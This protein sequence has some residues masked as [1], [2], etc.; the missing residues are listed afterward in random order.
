MM[1][2]EKK[3]TVIFSVLMTAI[4]VV[5]SCVAYFY[6]ERALKNQIEG[7]AVATM[8]SYSNK[9]NGWLTNKAAILRTKAA[10]IH[11][12]TGNESVTFPMVSGIKEAD[13]DIS[14]F[15]FGT[16][17]DGAI[18]DGSGWTPPAGF[19]ARTR[20]WY[21]DAMTAGNLTFSE[22]YSDAI[23]K[24]IAISISMPIKNN[25]G[26]VN[27]VLSEDV[28][29]DTL[30][31]NVSEIHPFKDSNAFLLNDKGTIMAY[32]NKDFVDKDIKQVDELAPLNTAL[33][34]ANID[35]QNSGI[36]TYSM[37]G[38]EN[39]LVYEKIPATEW[40]L[41]VNI[42][43]AVIYAPL[44][45]L[46][47]I[48]IIGT[49]LALLIVLVVTRMVAKRITLP[50]QVL[51]GH[52]E[53]IAAGDFTQKIEITGH[54]EIAILGKD[55]N[56]M[57]NELYSLI[58]KVQEK[59]DTIAA[60]SEEL[61]ASAA[62][63]TQAANQVAVSITKVADGT[64]RQTESTNEVAATVAHVNK[65]IE[66][67]VNNSVEVANESTQV[68]EHA[69]KGSRDVD[70]MVR[71][72]EEIEKAVQ[73]ST[74]VIVKL[75]EQSKHIG[76]IT[77]TISGIASQTNLLAL[78]AA[79]E[80][81]RAGEQGRGFAVVAEEVRK[82]AE[83]VQQAAQKIAEE[84]NMVQKDTESAVVRYYW[85]LLFHFLRVASVGI[86]GNSLKSIADL[87]HT[88]SKGIKNIHTSL[89]QIADNSEKLNMSI[90]SIDNI[91]KTNSDE[92]Q[93]VSAAAQQQLASMDEITSASQ[94]L[95][96]MAQEL[97]SA[98]NVFKVNM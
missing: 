77:D 96:Q 23:T 58:K 37:N 29:I 92:S 24:K 39:L 73:N 98:T 64:N 38:Q 59:S 69:D 51:S 11:Q 43:T 10:T 61:T 57:R 81:A 60:S 2:L 65:T 95:A 44:I 50:L 6:A 68:A 4:I 63:T 12:L 15:Y 7:K 87:I 70:S 79:I 5:I 25:A 13:E 36:V 40:L 16:A 93:M 75:G 33:G 30:L 14:D 19:D 89:Q 3:L 94:S 91:S 54:D 97:Q 76:Q 8:D 74:S 48:F 71:N 80:A 62:Q 45:A 49:V 85:P 20:S 31:K 17:A 84:I 22:P 72:M 53:K 9:L 52:V 46:R 56:K 88:S 28:L 78:N 27:G 32:P 47:W 1:N 21:K 82:L 41:G 86:V 55:F 67:I 66:E 83:E 26:Q 90:K 18:I 42:P 35:N 34:N